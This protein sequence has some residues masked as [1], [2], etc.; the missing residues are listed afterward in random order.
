ME[1]LAYRLVEDLTLEIVCGML[2]D[3]VSNKKLAHSIGSLR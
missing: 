1:K 3:T 2:H